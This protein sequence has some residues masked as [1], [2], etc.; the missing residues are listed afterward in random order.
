MTAR[1]ARPLQIAID[2][3]ELFGSPTGVGRYLLELLRCWLAPG[4][5]THEFVLYSPMPIEEGQESLRGLLLESGRADL[6]HLPGRPGTWWQQRILRKALVTDRP[7]VFFAPAY[8]APVLLPI[9]L[10]LAIHDASFAA[11]P[12]WFSWRTGLRLRC[13]ARVAGHAAARVLT[14]TRFS[15]D[16]IVTHVGLS[17]HVI[18]I[19]PP[20]VSQRFAQAP[21][22]ARE[23]LLLHVG[24]LLTRRGIPDLITAFAAVARRRLDARLV[25]VGPNRTD[26]FVDPRA[27]A[28]RAGIGDRVTVMDYVSDHGL[29][30]LYRTARAFAFLSSYEGFALTPL[31][32]LASGVPAVLL[33]TVVAREVYGDAVRYVAPGDLV[34]TAAAIE[35]LLYD[36]GARTALGARAAETL[37]RYAWPRAARRVLDIIEQVAG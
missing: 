2:A 24:T 3:T 29:L 25:I 6:R 16:E 9:P 27:L 11:H 17:S 32:A 18:E 34:A 31:E 8:T 23:P 21:P 5:N 26:P 35:D 12:E 20:G 10:V 19:V 36:E 15:R 13:L 7:D 28:V 14:L 1:G 22:H 4:S 33:D 37:A 30:E